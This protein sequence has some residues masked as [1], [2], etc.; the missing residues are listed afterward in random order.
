VRAPAILLALGMQPGAAGA[1]AQPGNQLPVRVLLPHAWEESSAGWLKATSKP[2]QTLGAGAEQPLCVHFFC[3]LFRNSPRRRHPKNRASNPGVFLHIPSFHP[4]RGLPRPRLS[5]Q[6]K[7]PS[8]P[9]RLP[10]LLLL[11]FQRAPMPICSKRCFLCRRASLLTT[12][13]PLDSSKYL[14][15]FL[16]VT[17]PAL[18]RHVYSTPSYR[19]P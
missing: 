6:S 2:R 16:A 8:L 4:T 13:Y 12:Q 10:T 19:T 3:L 14:Q 7:E 1:E 11:L 9:Q 18:N 5:L 15:I 17:L